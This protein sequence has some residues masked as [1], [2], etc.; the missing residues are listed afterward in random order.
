[1]IR[2]DDITL[3][4]HVDGVLDRETS[5]A[6][7]A[8]LAA[9][10]R[11]RRDAARLRSAALVARMA[12]DE[13][14]WSDP[15]ARLVEPLV[16]SPRIV[17]V[18]DLLG[19]WRL[20]PGRRA[21]S[22]VA[23][24]AGMAAGIFFAVALSP[25]PTMDDARIA[26]G[27]VAPDSRLH[28][29][30]DLYATGGQPDHAVVKRSFA[31][32]ATFK[33]KAGQTCLELDQFDRPADP[34]PEFVLVAC[35]SVDA[36]WTVLGGARTRASANVRFAKEEEAAH[37]AVRGILTMIGAEQRATAVETQGRAQ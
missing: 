18:A 19:R 14:M 37:E 9:D 29:V 32:V 3:M 33:N 11:G 21:Q 34:V 23:A 28:Q 35:R 15:P 6:I 22:V 24:L 12:F 13:P 30:L 17:R 5:R 27:P 7:D 4:A 16:R 36:G 25:S 20:G 1:M 2:P 10:A 31:L 26:M 8:H